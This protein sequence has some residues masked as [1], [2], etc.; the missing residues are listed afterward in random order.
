MTRR[1]Q[2]IAST[3][4]RAIQEV[5]ARGLNDPRLNALITV[6]AVKVTA[7]LR[8]ATVNV[9]VMPEKKQKLVLHGLEHSSR[10]IRRRV[11]DIVSL[12][13][14]P[15]LTFHLDTSLKQQ[16]R[17]LEAIARAREEL[18]REGAFDKVEKIEDDRSADA[19]LRSESTTDSDQR[20]DG[21][22][23]PHPAREQEKRP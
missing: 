5:L 19:P 21:S 1:Q 4:H 12:A 2:R 13:Q 18:E 11:G 3:L 10:H 15:Q 9:S 23:Q 14:M 22:D 17:T 16:A 8:S 6:T 20:T 7:D